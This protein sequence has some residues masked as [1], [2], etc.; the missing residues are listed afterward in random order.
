M[1][2]LLIRN[3]FHIRLVANKILKQRLLNK[4]ENEH[5][6]LLPWNLERKGTFARP[7]HR[8]RI[9]QVAKLPVT[10]TASIKVCI[11]AVCNTRLVETLIQSVLC[12]TES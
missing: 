11:F 5:R 9:I 12:F 7:R 6:T 8:F 10:F 4:R 2:S 1:Y 3:P